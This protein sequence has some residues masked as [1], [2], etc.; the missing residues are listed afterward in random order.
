ML[1][2]PTEIESEIRQIFANHPTAAYVA[3]VRSVRF[4]APDVAILRAVAG[5]VLPGQSDLNPALNAHQTLVSS[6]RDGI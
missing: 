5:M 3:K 2:G 1:D 4:L 6:K